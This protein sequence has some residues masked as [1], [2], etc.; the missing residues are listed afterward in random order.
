MQKLCK[1]VP[2]SANSPIT[3][4]STKGSISF[5]F[6]GDEKTIPL[7]QFNALQEESAEFKAC[8]EMR[9]IVTSNVPDPITETST[10]GTEDKTLTESD[11]QLSATPKK[12]TKTPAT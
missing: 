11:E 7:E 10:P 4:A 2:T 12:S 6:V 1:Y 5:A 9:V 3:F 8:L